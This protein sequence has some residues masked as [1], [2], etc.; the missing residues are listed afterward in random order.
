MMIVE[1]ENTVWHR[2][3]EIDLFLILESNLIWIDLKN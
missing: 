1:I 2:T 3:L